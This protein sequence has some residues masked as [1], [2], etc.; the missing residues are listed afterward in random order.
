[1]C[2]LIRSVLP[3]PEFLTEN[4]QLETK[5]HNERHPSRSEMSEARERLKSR[6]TESFEMGKHR[7]SL[8]SELASKLARRDR[9]SGNAHAQQ[10]PVAGSLLSGVCS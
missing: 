8:A 3:D 5:P 6:S 7:R 2:I 10:I 4:A 9:L 1:M